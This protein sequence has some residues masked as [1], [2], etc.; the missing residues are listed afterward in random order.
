MSDGRQS[1]GKVDQRLLLAGLVLLLAIPITFVMRDVAREMIVVPLLYFLWLGRLLWQSLPQALLWILF[2]VLGLYVAAKSLS[3]ERDRTRRG[4]PVRGSAK[5]EVGYPGPVAVWARRVELARHREYYRWYLAQ[6]LGRLAQEV[7]AYRARLALDQ[8][9]PPQVLRE[10]RLDI[11]PKIRAYFEVGQR[12]TP[13]RYVRFP[14]LSRLISRL[15]SPAEDSPLSLDPERVIR[16]L[17][18][19]LED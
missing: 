4:G 2:L 14:R 13:P 7:L 3:V 12:L 6:Q 9:E 1:R 17:E 8:V 15:R 16:F 18:R 5:D 10:D 11:P 19:Q